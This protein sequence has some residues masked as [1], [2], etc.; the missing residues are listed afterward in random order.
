MPLE[1]VVVGLANVT[2]SCATKYL[3]EPAGATYFTTSVV[4]EPLIVSVTVLGCATEKVAFEGSFTVKDLVPIDC[5][6]PVT[7]LLTS[8]KEMLGV[9][10]DPIGMATSSNFLIVS[11]DAFRGLS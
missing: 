3:E 4:V 7:A 6:I 2:V 11:G 10:V 1:S 9:V 8:V 5:D